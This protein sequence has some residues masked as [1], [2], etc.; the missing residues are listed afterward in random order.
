MQVDKIQLLLQNFFLVHPLNLE[1][2]KAMLS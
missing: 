2:R 1:N